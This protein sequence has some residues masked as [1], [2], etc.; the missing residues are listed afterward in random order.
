M[1][2]STTVPSGAPIWIDLATSDLAA[3]R[4]FYDTLFGWES[5]E[6]DPHMGG[7][8]NFIHHGE[9]VAGCMP[10]MPGSPSDVCGRSISPAT[11]PRAPAATS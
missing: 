10:A 3:S 2:T 5:R 11:T 7:Y 4:A 1:P 8:L 6:P 9:R